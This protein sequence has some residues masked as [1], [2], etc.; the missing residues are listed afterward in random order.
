MSGRAGSRLAWIVWGTDVAL[1][2]LWCVLAVFGLFA[3]ASTLGTIGIAFT[4]LVPP[5]IG[6]LILSRRPGN[7]IG[8]ILYGMGIA[9]A[10]TWCARAYVE[11]HRERPAPAGLLDWEWVAWVGDWI[12]LPPGFAMLT[13]ALLLFP[14]GRLPSNRWRPVA[15]FAV[16]LIAGL[17]AQAAIGRSELEYVVYPDPAPNPAYIGAVAD[18]FDSALARIVG[19][20]L[21]PVVVVGAVAAQVVGM[22][23]ARGVERQQRKWF[24]YLGS[25]VVIIAA[26]SAI[27]GG[28][29]PETPSHPWVNEA[30]WYTFMAGPTVG[31]PLAIGIAIFRYQLYDVDLVINRTLVYLT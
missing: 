15:V 11:E 23:Q 3:A 2:V 10:V 27:A 26:G 31:M 12:W 24:A 22:R 16:A 28:A 20:V 6:A 21:G 29:A 18:F 5:T 1:I 17:T 4:S 13:V 9:T 30:F 14:D 8:W 7:A 19:Y 25:V